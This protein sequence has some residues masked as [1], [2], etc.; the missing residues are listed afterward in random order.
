METAAARGPTC[1][2]RLQDSECFH[3]AFIPRSWV[4][5]PEPRSFR[6][7]VDIQAL[8]SSTGGPA[9][10]LASSPSGYLNQ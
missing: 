2:H 5:G 3:H 4:R 7:P 10:L 6:S 9:V 8:S 1:E